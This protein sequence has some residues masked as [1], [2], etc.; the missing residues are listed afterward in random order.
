[1]KNP[2]PNSPLWATLSLTELEAALQKLSGMERAQAYHYVT[3][4]LNAC[5]AAV[6]EAIADSAEYPGA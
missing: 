3:L 1:M 6:E 4:T 2:I 5:H